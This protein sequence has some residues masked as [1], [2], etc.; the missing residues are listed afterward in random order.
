MAF[1]PT[2]VQFVA[3]GLNR[4]LGQL[5][6]AN[7]AQQGLGGA[8]RRVGQDYLLLGNR[9]LQIGATIAKFATGAVGVATVAVGALGVASLK[10]AISFESAFAG[11]GKTVDDVSDSTGKLTEIGKELRAEFV[12]LTKE[13]P[14][15]F[16]ELAK[17]GELGGQLGIARDQLLGFSETI[18]ALGVSTNLTTE[19][20]ETAIARFQNI[21]QV[22]ADDVAENTSRVGSAIVDLGNNFATTESEITRFSERMAAA[23]KI[24]GLTQADVLAIGTAMSSVGIEAEAGGTA[25]QKTL[26][27]INKAVTQSSGAF[28]EQGRTLNDV[29]KDIAKVE[30]SLIE[31]EGATRISRA[32][33]AGLV[34]AF[35]DSGGAV[36]DFATQLGSATNVEY[37]QTIQAL[38]A[39]QQEQIALAT[40]SKEDID[41]SKL[42]KFA[43]VA[44]VSAEKFARVWK[45]D[46][47]QGFQLFVEGLGDA[48]DNAALI[49][50]DLGLKDTR[51]QR[52]FLSLAESGDVL[53]DAIITGNQA[54]AENTAL[55]EEAAKRYATVESKIQIFKNTLRALGDEIGTK[56]FP[57]FGELL[58][59]GQ[60]LIGRWSKPILDAIDNQVIPAFDRI[61]NIASGLGAAFRGS[62]A[63]GAAGFLAQTLGLS[64][65]GVTATIELVQKVIDTI[66]DITTQLSTG[67]QSFPF[68][69][70][71]SQ[72]I[73]FLNDNFETIKGAIIAVAAL[74]A[75]AGIAA[76]LASILNP[77]TAMITL[78]ALLGAAWVSNFGGI[79]EKTQIAIAVITKAFDILSQTIM[80]TLGP[81]IEELTTS[82]GSLGITWTDVGN[83]LLQATQIVFAA[84]GAIFLAFVGTVVSVVGAVSDAFQTLLYAADILKQSFQNVVTGILLILQGDLVGGVT[85]ILVGL[86]QGIAGA[87][88]G[89]FGTILS[90]VGGFVIT[91]IEFFDNLYMAL[92]GGS[93]IPDL[94]NEMIYWFDSLIEPILGSLQSLASGVQSILGS[95]FSGIFGGDESGFTS[96]I[97]DAIGLAEQA[98]RFGDFVEKAVTAIGRFQSVLLSTLGPA[99]ELF[100]KTVLPAWQAVDAVLLSVVNNTLF[101]Q[102]EILPGLSSKLSD[103]GKAFSE[104][105]DANAIGQVASA[106][107]TIVGRL[108][109]VD[110]NA[111]DAKEALSG[112]NS[113]SLNSILNAT[114]QLRDNLADALSAAQDLPGALA[115]INVQPLGGFSVESASSLSTPTLSP[116]VQ[117]ASPDIPS[118]Q[119]TG[120]ITVSNGMDLAMFQEAIKQTVAEAFG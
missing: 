96:F 60:T 30:A 29:N 63:A 87:F 66:T 75:S 27:S 1:T 49:L 8:A 48:G 36:G 76:A 97:P 112:L 3:K 90:L 117:S 79:Q 57:I 50:D 86:A 38:Q 100:E 82:L 42:E 65:E 47:S 13:I 16:E 120:P 28:I 74:L 26:L 116:I 111:D 110:E 5:A 10:T 33:M 113:V 64:P 72:A 101:L 11:V 22:A 85:T 54:F 19:E 71:I 94:I 35:I 105:F 107:D 40:G 4:Y 53:G 80:A 39:L 55:T 69:D 98:S 70:T 44:G 81:V 45:Q 108:G 104:A 59:F 12:Q 7:R 93:I 23:G 88:V 95:I 25:V 6:L 61:K 34:D 84:I 14:I 62:G 17:I 24:A 56:L 103:V 78:S 52:A 115:N 20:A 114:A 92:V 2:G 9:V 109:D 58:T 83:A 102:N 21:Y 43:Q 106:I 67:A 118:V 46:A 41:T 89:T 32:E 37:A 99:I 18:A 15:T 91:M 119:F 51:L 31:F 68:L 73:I 77:I